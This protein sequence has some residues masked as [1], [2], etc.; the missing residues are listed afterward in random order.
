MNRFSGT[1]NKLVRVGADK[2]AQKLNL[3]QEE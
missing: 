3:K 1:S 2:K